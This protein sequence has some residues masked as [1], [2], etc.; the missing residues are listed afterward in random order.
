M[1]AQ[2]LIDYC[3]RKPSAYVN[4]PFG[5]DLV[6]ARIGSRIFAEIFLTQPWVTL[7]CEP[8]YGQAMRQTYP[9]AIRRGYHCPPLQHPYNNT[10]LLTG[11][12]PEDEILRMA[13]HSY[14]YTLGKL[15]KAERQEALSCSQDAD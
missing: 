7:K 4:C 1:T 8:L 3:L 15:S 5:P 14:D 2:T 13:D 12:V 10:I 6:C 11:G 9:E